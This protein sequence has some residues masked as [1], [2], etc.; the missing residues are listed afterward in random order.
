MAI[1]EAIRERLRADAVGG[2]ATEGTRAADADGGAGSAP[3][4]GRRGSLL[5]GR[6]EQLGPALRSAAPALLTYAAT[7][8]LSLL[9]LGWMASVRH[10][11]PWGRLSKYDGNW[12]IG[13][14]QHGYNHLVTLRPDGSPVNTN[15]AF[16][17]GYPLLLRALGSGFG[18]SA[19]AA[20]LVVSALAGLAASWAIYLIGRD[21]HG[22]RTGVVLVALWSTLPV[23]LVL[24]MVYTEALFTAFAASALLAVLRRRWLTAGILCVLAG[25]TRSSAVAVVAALGLAAVVAIVRRQDG[26]RPWL[27]AAIAPTGLLAFWAWVGKVLGRPDGWF[28]MQHRGWR[29]SF[30]YGA[31]TLSH[32]EHFLTSRVDF[33]WTTTAILLVMTVLAWILMVQDRTPAPLVVYG[34]TLVLLALGT[35]GYFQS[36]PRMLLPAFPLLLVPAL[37]LSRL[38]LR[39]LAIILGGLALGSAWYGAYLL[40]VFP[41]AL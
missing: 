23:S 19:F 14:A 9:M 26:W 36:R 31:T 32:T 12:Y 21:V 38:R 1:P 40:V 24:S 10:V 16:F 15:L 3:G 6:V 25:L 27:A 22:H 20:G 4:E 39:P 30:D 37:V 41:Y 35:T 17:P 13:V 11:D 5:A 2:T 7:R 33:V 29:M 28:W 18:W 34:T 8:V